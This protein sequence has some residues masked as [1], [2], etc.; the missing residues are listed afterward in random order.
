MN[1]MRQVPAAVTTSLSEAALATEGN[2][3]TNGHAAVTS[4]PA[5]RELVDSYRRLADVFHHVLSEQALDTLLDRI[6]DTLAELIPY[7][8]LSIFEANEAQ[9]ELVPMLARDRA[10]DQIMRNPLELATGL[11]GRAPKH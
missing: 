10:D 8:T 3:T 2:G 1:S 6:A 7:D 11:T 9:T 4:L 5:H